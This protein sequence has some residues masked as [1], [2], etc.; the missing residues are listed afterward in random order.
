MLYT[1]HVIAQTLAVTRMVNPGSYTTES[2]LLNSRSRIFIKL[3]HCA[4]LLFQQL[5][6]VYVQLSSDD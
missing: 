5:K 3:Y 1:K 2:A 6:A 4:E